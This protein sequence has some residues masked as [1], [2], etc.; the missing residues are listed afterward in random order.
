MHEYDFADPV[1]VWRAVCGEPSDLVALLLH[2]DPVS[3]RTRIAMAAW[4]SGALENAP[5]LKRGAALDA[6]TPERVR[7]DAA[8]ANYCRV[9]GWVRE[10][11]FDI[12]EDSLLRQVAR[13]WQLAPAALRDHVTRFEAAGLKTALDVEARAFRHWQQRTGRAPRH[14]FP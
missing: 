8:A 9:V 5:K 13:K 1:E 12:D 11:G 10:R 2:E 3:R 6:L 7:C 14:T 4:L